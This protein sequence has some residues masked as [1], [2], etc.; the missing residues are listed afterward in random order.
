VR[1]LQRAWS[2]FRLGALSCLLLATFTPAA[3]AARVTIDPARLEVSTF[4]GQAFVQITAHVDPGN[5]PIIVV[6]GPEVEELFDRKVR[7]GPI[8]I[9]S[10]RARVSGVP[11]LLLSLTPAPLG[12]MVSADDIHARQLDAR[13]VR[14]RM[15]VEPSAA[16][17]ADVRDSY[18]ALKTSD[19]SFRAIDPGQ[20]RV[21]PAGAAGVFVVRLP[22]PTK[23][24][25]GTYT[26]TVYECC[27]RRITHTQSVTLD[28]VQVGLSAWLAEAAAQHAGLYATVAVGVTMS[29]GFGI[30]FLVTAARRVR[31]RRW[32]RTAERP[33]KRSADNSVATTDEVRR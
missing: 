4:S 20:V 10:G 24:R 30:D 26:V 25:P 9:N 22:W 13:A 28:V 11:A 23:A 31:A 33:S 2:G 8:W 5:L 18:L 32:R 17:S 19:G 15:R 3:R 16:D 12:E 1:L 14:T 27:E 21:E 6:R 29:L 7:F